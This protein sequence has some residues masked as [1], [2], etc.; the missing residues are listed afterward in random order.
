MGIGLAC[1]GGLLTW[2][3]FQIRRCN[4]FINTVAG[5]ED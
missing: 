3:A 1:A 4:Q 5:D 2:L